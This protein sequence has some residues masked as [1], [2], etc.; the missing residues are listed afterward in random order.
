MGP[1]ISPGK[2][3]WGTRT[4]SLAKMRKRFKLRPRRIVGFLVRERATCVRMWKGG[5]S[6]VAHPYAG[7]EGQTFGE[8]LVLY[9]LLPASPDPQAGRSDLTG[10][11]H[12]PS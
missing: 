3:L 10:S 8:T 2:R 11:R 4:H 7:C 9:P 1:K 5:V 6:V 12:N